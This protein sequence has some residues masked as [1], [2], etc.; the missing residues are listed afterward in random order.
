MRI[1][2]RQWRHARR[3]GR[4]RGPAGRAVARLSRHEAAVVEA[5]P[6]AR[7]RR[8]PGDRARSARLRRE[9]Q[10]R[11]S[12]GVL[13]P[14]PR[15][16]RRRRSSITSASSAR[17][18][19]VTTGARRSRGRRRRSRPTRRSPRCAVGRASVARSPARACRSA[20]SRGTC[21]CSSSPAVAEQWL[22]MDNWANFR[23]W[24]TSP[25]RRR[26]DRRSR[27]RRLAHDRAQLVPRQHSARGAH[28]AAARAAAG[29]GA[30]DGRVERSTT[31]R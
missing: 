2:S 12:R 24:C 10:A 7:R 5:G 29:A 16:R 8:L 1:D 27:T 20:R 23:E 26:G 21:C 13:D 18:S 22:S 6:G 9:R 17:T 3:A 31:S 15:D 30:D 25:R 14:V 19:S 11:R 28:R 4:R